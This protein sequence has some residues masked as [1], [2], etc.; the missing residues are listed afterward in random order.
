MNK[1]YILIALVAIFFLYFYNQS[2]NSA[3][4]QPTSGGSIVVTP[5]TQNQQTISYAQADIQGAN[6]STSNGVMYATLKGIT[7]RVVG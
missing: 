1:K 6:F 7:Y 4:T 3:A 2:K 5:P